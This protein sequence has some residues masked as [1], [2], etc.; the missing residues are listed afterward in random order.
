VGKITLLGALIFCL[1]V[2]LCESA[3]LGHFGIGSSGVPGQTDAGTHDIEE[4]NAMF[5]WTMSTD[6]QFALDH[7][8]G[9]PAIWNGSLG[10]WWTLGD[11]YDVAQEYQKWA[12]HGR[13]GL[14]DI[15][16]AE[17]VHP[18]GLL[19]FLTDVGTSVSAF[20]NT[21]GFSVAGMPYA[22]SLFNWFLTF[23]IVLCI[24]LIIRGVD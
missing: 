2:M 20:A 4:M 1:V 9:N 5:Q 8:W 10:D 23:V 18:G 15:A 21:L 12:N 16:N 7:D 3:V 11:P 22:V 17:Q 13:Q 24:A 6:H 14:A 19:G